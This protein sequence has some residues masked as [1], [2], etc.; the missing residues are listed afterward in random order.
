MQLI[1]ADIRGFGRLVDRHLPFASQ[2][3]IVVGS[4]EA[5]K[6]TLQ[7]FLLAALFGLKREGRKRRDYLPQYDRYRPW[8][9]AP[10]GGS[11]R[12]SLSNG[13][14][15]EVRRDFDRDSES[16]QLFDAITGVERTEQFP[17]DLRKE[18]NFMLEQLHLT[19][20]LFEATTSLGQLA[21]QP[22]EE[23]AGAFRERIQ[24]LLDSGDED[25][26]TRHALRVLQ[27]LREQF[28]SERTP[29]RG[30]GLLLARK[31]DLLHELEF[32]QDR[33]TE[34][35]AL[36]ARRNR[37]LLEHQQAEEAWRRA[38]NVEL[39]RQRHRLQQRLLRAEALEK[40]TE[41]MT[42]DLAQFDDVIE[43]DINEYSN[44]RER[45][46][47]IEAQAAALPSHEQE[48]QQLHT[49]LE[50]LQ[51]F[52]EVLAGALGDMDR[53]QRRAV[54]REAERL[55]EAMG[56]FRE[57]RRRNL[58][59]QEVNKSVVVQLAK[60][61]GRD[62]TRDDFMVRLAAEEASLDTSR[63]QALLEKVQPATEAYVKARNAVAFR[64]AL[65]CVAV[66][67]LTA[68]NLWGPGM[69]PPMV[70]IGVPLVVA[71]LLLAYVPSGLRKFLVKRDELGA[72]RSHLAHLLQ[73][74]KDARIWIQDALQRNHMRQVEDLFEAHRAFL[75]LEAASQENPQS[76]ALKER[77][78]SE[79]E[80]RLEAQ[81]F[82]QAVAGC[83][84]EALRGLLAKHD[85]AA[86]EFLPFA[87]D[88]NPV[89]EEGDSSELSRLAEDLRL[90][91]ELR[92][93]FDWCDRLLEEC[94][95]VE[96]RLAEIAQ[97]LQRQQ[98]TIDAAR[99]QLLSVFEENGV[100]DLQG[101]AA[102]ATRARFRQSAVAAL[103]PLQSEMHGVLN[104]ETIAALRGRIE[105][106]TLEM[107]QVAPPDTTSTQH[108][109]QWPAP[110]ETVPSVA[111]EVKPLSLEA[112]SSVV[113]R[114]AAERAQL[115][116]RLT[117]RERE[118]RSSVEVQLELDEVETQIHMEEH[119]DQALVLAMET[120]E[121]VSAQ[122]HREVAPQMNARVGEFFHRLSLGKHQ[123]VHLDETLTPRIRSHGGQF[124]D[125]DS[126][127][128]GAADQLYF[129]VRVTAGEQLARS[130]ERLPLL[131]DD[132]FVQY[133][134]ERMIAA[135][136]VVT[137]LALDHQVF[138]FTCEESQ[139]EILLRRGR[140]RGLET[141]VDR[142]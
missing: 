93:G 82:R 115:E 4:N 139:A 66:V 89:I 28:G 87:E 18:R 16:L 7:Q 67:A 76:T 125:V 50:D 33:H 20:Q 135:M 111:D 68:T 21:G 80:L 45:A 79:E 34:T 116:E 54:E 1:S 113:E 10:Y 32:S 124:R 8:D 136:E 127:S 31:S 110:G 84:F 85:A 35:L 88:A 104:G 114:L 109:L 38:R 30:R 25:V 106:L 132:P 108:Q 123:E 70:L 69:I 60:H 107:S 62:W 26:S 92:R 29:S 133:D 138:F 103:A 140:D 128:G 96:E 122:L 83:D 42:A 118:G 73:R 5:G 24:G 39:D 117:A 36:Y 105:A 94:R 100:E 112:L 44:V 58:Q 121:R 40:Q 11:L 46:A 37:S 71:V 47:A 3:Q 52:Q 90:L 59:Q 75:S 65:G 91:P 126:L 48:V 64:L 102:R 51:A 97:S 57:A 98:D 78:E 81:Q 61:R 27:G 120:L 23:G 6:S 15:W 53:T 14:Q 101:F 131:L 22:S 99:R 141:A 142:L 95:R 13:E 137:E 72:L 12:Y 19:R 55:R 56:R 86:H 74:G 41:E 77:Q 134:P 119:R 2:M 43:F 17:L 130:G 49:R 63:R 9:G 129:A